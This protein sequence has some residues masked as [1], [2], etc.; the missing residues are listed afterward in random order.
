MGDQQPPKSA[1]R[2]ACSRPR[3][4]RQRR[5]GPTQNQTPQSPTKSPQN[6][7]QQQTQDET[8]PERYGMTN[9]HDP[10]PSHPHLAIAS[11]GGGGGGAAMVRLV[12]QAAATSRCNPPRTLGNRIWVSTVR[13]ATEVSYCTRLLL[14]R[15]RLRRICRPRDGE[16]GVSQK[17]EEMGR[18]GRWAR[19]RWADW[20]R[21]PLATT[22]S[23]FAPRA[24]LAQKPSLEA[25]ALGEGRCGWRTGV[26][27]SGLEGLVRW[28]VAFL[29][30]TNG[31]GSGLV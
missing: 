3:I 14:L 19:G 27:L 23:A 29:G 25:G 4:I 8:S 18:W 13:D 15:L 24:Q 16:G 31:L 26:L 10:S 9:T 7:D 6:T 22:P 11:T 30:L 2:Q 20:E 17:G 28:A 5:I 21:R 12:H 1:G